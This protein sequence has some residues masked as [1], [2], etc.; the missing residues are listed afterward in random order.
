[1]RQSGSHPCH[2]TGQDTPE[3]VGVEAGSKGILDLVLQDRC[4]LVTAQVCACNA[5]A[6]GEAEAWED[7]FHPENT[8]DKQVI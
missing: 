6:T 4:H 8:R 2:A 1:M 7:N 3:A 5:V